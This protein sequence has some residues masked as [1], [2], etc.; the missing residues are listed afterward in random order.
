MTDT[1]DILAR[2]RS[3]MKRIR[4]RVSTALRE[5]EERYRQLVESAPDAVYIFSEDIVQFTNTAGALYI[6]LHSARDLIGRNVMD[7]LGPLTDGVTIT[8]DLMIDGQPGRN[9]TKEAP[10]ADV[11]SAMTTMLEQSSRSMATRVLLV[12]ND[13][14]ARTFETRATPIQWNGKIAVQL[15]V[16]DVTAYTRV[17]EQLQEYGER[18]RSLSR[19]LI[20]TQESE[21]RAIAIELHDEAGQAVLNFKHR[22]HALSRALAD[23]GLRQ[24]IRDMEHILDFYTDKLRSLSLELRPSMLDD[25]GV[26]AAVEWYIDQVNAKSVVPVQ[27]LCSDFGRAVPPEVSI[28]CFRIVQEAVTN[29]L[30]HANASTIVVELHRR[31]DTLRLS[32]RDDGE[33]FDVMAMQAAATRGRSLGLLGM[34]ERTALA[35]GTLDIRSV[36][37]EGT[38]IDVSFP[39]CQ[40][41]R[42]EV[43]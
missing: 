21:R 11:R 14:E 6:G 40:I 28:A 33:G 16:R 18:L 39:L 15:S 35:F 26:I 25:L 29:A 12:R 20:L 17:E 23:E 38:D 32:I 34:Q 19:Q 27:L 3:R 43:R 24:E 4:S 8:T 30:R 13:G 5:S 22:L 42:P 37:G 41:P 31:E 36:P 2:C 7:L 1:H 9:L 10:I